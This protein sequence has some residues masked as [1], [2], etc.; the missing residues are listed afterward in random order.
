[1]Q[2]LV[3]TNGTH[4]STMG[5]FRRENSLIIFSMPF[6]DVSMLNDCIVL[7]THGILSYE[8]HILAFFQNFEFDIAK[9]N[10]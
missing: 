4:H 5:I 2:L 7:R 8:L 10:A 1:M 3:Y 6:I 9:C